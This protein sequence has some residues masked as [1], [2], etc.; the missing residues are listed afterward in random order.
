MLGRVYS[1]SVL[2]IDA[3]PILAE[4]DVKDGLPSFSMVGALSSE[5]K[6]AKERVRIALENSGYRLP[7]KRIT[8]NLSPADIRKDGTSFDLS[9]AI[10]VL[11]A[12]GFIPEEVCKNFIFLGE[13]C[14]DG[15]IGPVAG[16]LVVACMARE[17]GFTSLV[18]PKE[19]AAE[20]ALAG[21][22]TVY[23]AETLS[24]VVEHLAGVCPMRPYC[25]EEM[26]SEALQ[27]YP[28][29]SE[30]HG[31]KMA[32]RA[33]EIAAAGRHN[34]LMI[35]PP[36]TGKTM[37]AKRLPSILPTLSYEECLE[38]SKIYSVVG[39]LGEEKKLILR[40]PFQAPHHTI[41]DAAFA[42][43]GRR[44]TPG[45]ISL[46]HKGVLFLD[47]FPEFKRS[48]I[49]VLREPL[50]ERKITVTRLD[51]AYTY[52]AGGMLVAAMN[53]C[54]CGYYPD[55]TRCNCSEHQ[56][57]QYLGKISRPL[58]DRIDLCVSVVQI[59][60]GELKSEEAVEN[61]DSIRKRVEEARERQNER[62]KEIAANTNAELSSKDVERFCLLSENARKRMDYAYSKYMF[63][64]RAYHR[65]MK[66]ARTIADLAGTENI[67]EEALLEALSYRQP[68]LDYWGMQR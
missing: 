41:S 40:P 53:P 16:T 36:G 54:N 3:E 6:E 37:L 9:V 62:Y 23:A 21:D 52:P 57:R 38:I 2:G 19:N 56:V 43:G 65:I 5:T 47:E 31:Q 44:A 4:A 51:A 28:D 58:L 25:E 45:I 34:V 8:V 39:L 60:L 61:S 59:P 66:T 13:L 24:E 7:V 17:K 33:L 26:W 49:E 14:F 15:R 63:S 64:A 35:G 42:G 10:A 67:E 48:T 30:V 50:E 11:T 1:A 46:A 68:E 55:K 20:A 18:V 29:F 32:K 12:F 22:L 27:K